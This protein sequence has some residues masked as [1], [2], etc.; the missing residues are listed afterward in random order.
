MVPHEPVTALFPFDERD[1]REAS[2]IIEITFPCYN[3]LHV[4]ASEK[5]LVSKRRAL[6]TAGERIN[7]G[8]YKLTR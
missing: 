5:G 1:K 8:D 3:T 7:M 6:C 2:A 4:H